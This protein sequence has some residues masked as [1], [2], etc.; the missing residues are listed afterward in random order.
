MISKSCSFETDRLDVSE[1]HLISSNE[2]WQENLAQVL[3]TMLTEPV[4][5]HLPTAF[6]G[7]YTVARARQWIR[8][9]DKEG[10]MLI[11][12]EK[13]SQDPVGL[14]FFVKMD[15]EETTESFEVRLGYLLSETVWG[16]GLATEMVRG[17]VGWC[18]T[19]APISTLVGGVDVD[20]PASMR[21]LEKNRFQSVEAEGEGDQGQRIYRLILR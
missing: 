13:T 9:R 20:H 6:H 21:V 12:I 18:R 5:R 2:T 19:Q 10:T 16:R 14:I 15:S 7:D 17:F 11:A 8:E 3:A 1:W 4:M